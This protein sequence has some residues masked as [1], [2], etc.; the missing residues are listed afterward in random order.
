[1]EEGRKE[2]QKEEGRKRGCM[3][4][5]TQRRKQGKRGRREESRKGEREGAIKKRTYRDGGKEKMMVERKGGSKK[6]RK[7]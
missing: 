3:D 1:M 6:G 4:V 2:V 5:S 7:G